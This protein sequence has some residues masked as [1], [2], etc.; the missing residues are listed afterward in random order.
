MRANAAISARPWPCPRCSAQ[1]EE[2]FE[3]D[4]GAGEKRRVGV[5]E[6]REAGDCAGIFGEQHFGVT[7]LAKEVLGQ[8]RFV[9]RHAS[10]QVLVLREG[11]DKQRDRGYVADFGGADHLHE[12]EARRVVDR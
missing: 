10:G 9:E 7:M 5:K 12:D 6:Q 1:H 8:R 3:P 2:V 4:A 11:A